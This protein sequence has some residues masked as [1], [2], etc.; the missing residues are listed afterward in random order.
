MSFRQWQDAQRFACSHLRVLLTSLNRCPDKVLESCE[1]GH[2]A[3]SCSA[4]LLGTGSLAGM[5]LGVRPAKGPPTD[6]PVDSGVAELAVT[7]SG[8]ISKAPVHVTE[9]E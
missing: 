7:A 5:G 4:E 1:G 2:L 3:W 8:V 9:V 6:H